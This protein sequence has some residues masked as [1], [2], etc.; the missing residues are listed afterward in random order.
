MNRRVIV[1]SQAK[2]DLR[3]ATAWYVAI[4]PAL[5]DD[6]GRRVDDAI[7]FET[8]AVAEYLLVSA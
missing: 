6:F 4:S 1:R 3:D 7:A 5:A 8:S 2:R